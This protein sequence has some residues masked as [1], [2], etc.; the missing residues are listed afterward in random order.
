MVAAHHPEVRR[1]HLLVICDCSFNVWSSSSLTL[2]DNVDNSSTAAFNSAWAFGA[3]INT[4]SLLLLSSRF[5]VGFD[6]IDEGRDET[7]GAGECTVSVL[8][9]SCVVIGAITTCKWFAGT[10]PLV[11][12]SRRASYQLLSTLRTKVNSSSCSND[13]CLFDF[14]LK[15]YFATAFPYCKTRNALTLCSMYVR[16]TIPVRPLASHSIHFSLMSLTIVTWS[17]FATDSS[18]MDRA[19]K[20]YSTLA[21]GRFVSFGPTRPWIS[22][23]FWMTGSR[24]RP[25]TARHGVTL[26]LCYCLVILVFFHSHATLSLLLN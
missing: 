17:P 9:E 10:R 22:S 11:V 12:L 19:L 8:I 21:V 23:A 18:R 4:S 1:F 16:G 3:L 6:T 26:P 24:K 20:V 2:I 13:T 14:F 25:S 15:P 7:D 5:S